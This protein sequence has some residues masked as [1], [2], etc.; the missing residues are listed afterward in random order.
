MKIKSLITPFKFVVLIVLFVFL[1]SC[2]SHTIIDSKP[3]GAKLYVNGEHVGN[4]P[5]QYSDR[6][7]VGSVTYVR[8][9]KDGY[10]PLLGYFV[11][12]QKF[13]AENFLTIF[14]YTPPLW[15]MEYNPLQLFELVP[16][17]ENIKE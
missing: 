2:K 13:V 11:R 3:S 6:K 14:L 8:M 16:I 17:Q 7:I 5:Y 4:T 15:I 12:D 10:E 9:E 1:S